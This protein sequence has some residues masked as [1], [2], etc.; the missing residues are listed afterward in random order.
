MKDQLNNDLIVEVAHTKQTAQKQPGSGIQQ[1]TGGSGGA[2][3]S[4][5]GGGGLGKER[6]PTP[7][8][9][10]RKS[11]PSGGGG[12]A[13]CHQLALVIRGRQYMPY[14]QTMAAKLAREN[15]QQSLNMANETTLGYYKS[16]PI[17]RINKRT[18]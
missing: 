17:Y 1:A 11:A 18:G 5:G 10:A 3:P 8:M 7:A 4:S 2:P 6:T 13:P 9:A 14:Q 12:K 16:N 15:R